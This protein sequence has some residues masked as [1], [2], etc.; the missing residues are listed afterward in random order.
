MKQQ[1]VQAKTHVFK[2]YRESFGSKL[3]EM[4]SAP[5]AK[6]TDKTVWFEDRGGL[7]FGSRRSIPLNEAHF[8]K[9]DAIAAYRKLLGKRG[10][11][12]EAELEEIEIQYRQ[13]DQ[14]AAKVASE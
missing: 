2:V 6:I 11:A 8:T 5:I 12:L 3:V 14:L 10:A 7:A 4:H 13:L 1:P 9:E